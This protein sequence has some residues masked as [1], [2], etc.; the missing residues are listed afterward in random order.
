VQAWATVWLL[1]SLSGILTTTAVSSPP[2]PAAQE[3]QENL[4]A[5]AE[6][7]QHNGDYRGAAQI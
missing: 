5:R 4:A 6:Q 1:G 2:W 7:A 3:A